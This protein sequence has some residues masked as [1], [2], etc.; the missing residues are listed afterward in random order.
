[1]LNYRNWRK[2]LIAGFVT[3]LIIFSGCATTKTAV[4]PNEL[5]TALET[6]VP[7]IPAAPL[8]E[9]VEFEDKDNGLHLSYNDYRALE[10][11]IIAMREYESRLLLL[12]EYYR[13]GQ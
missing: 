12:V 13:E 5:K 7:D 11:N 6:F 2:R 3:V 1:M 10:R 4:K 9:P 8:M